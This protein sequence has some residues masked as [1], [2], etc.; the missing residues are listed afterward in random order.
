[1]KL[2]RSHAAKWYREHID[3]L[4]AVVDAEDAKKPKDKAR[5]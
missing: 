5:L 3:Q 2:K 4:Y 1:M